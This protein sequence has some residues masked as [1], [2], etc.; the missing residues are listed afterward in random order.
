MTEK[1]DKAFI[2]HHCSLDFIEISKHRFKL[3][4][5]VVI[6]PGVRLKLEL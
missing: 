4:D 5:G 6:P 2:Y 1:N 3:S